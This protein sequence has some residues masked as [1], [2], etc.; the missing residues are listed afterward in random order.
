M[1]GEDDE[2]VGSGRVLG[3]LLERPD[4]A[5]DAVER[6]E[7]LHALRSAVVG[8]LVVVGEV[9][10]D[11]V[12]AAV[13][14]LD[15]QRGVDVAEEDVHAARMPAY[16]GPRCIWGWIPDR[17]VRRAWKSS[18]TNSPRNSVNERR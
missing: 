7:G 3:R 16:L 15:D 9:R 2:A 8:E 17:R 14:L 13:H 1:V 11:D 5:V 6:L 12:G 18:L 4:R 10:V